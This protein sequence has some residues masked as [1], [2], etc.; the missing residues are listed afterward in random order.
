L[1]EDSNL[2]LASATEA[3]TPDLT[4]FIE[5]LIG[6][7]FIPGIAKAVA[8][9]GDV[10]GVVELAAVAFG[11]VMNA[12]AIGFAFVGLFI[13][14]IENP[15]TEVGVVCCADAATGIAVAAGDLFAVPN[16]GGVQPAGGVGSPVPAGF[17]AGVELVIAADDVAGLRPGELDFVWLPN[18]YPEVAVFPASAGGGV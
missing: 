7:V 14:G 3:I 9:D 10:P 6:F 13:G 8:V 12:W 16:D 17:V 1:T 18:W 5:L 4:P 2:P 15:P 11:G